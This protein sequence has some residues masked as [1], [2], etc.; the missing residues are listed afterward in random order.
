MKKSQ[1]LNENW[2]KKLQG[3]GTYAKISHL[4]ESLP[5]S[6]QQV[7]F[8]L[9]LPKLLTHM[10]QAVNSCSNLVDNI[11]FVA[12][13]FQQVRYSHEITTLVGL[14]WR[15]RKSKRLSSLRSWV[16]FS[17]QTHVKESGLSDL[18][19]SCSNKSDTDDI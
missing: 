12:R 16:R 2:Q 14:Q 19:Q 3:L 8:A 1:R 7:V 17:L 6:R 9:L 18:L 15:S 11:R 4:V 10:E 5:T 13:L